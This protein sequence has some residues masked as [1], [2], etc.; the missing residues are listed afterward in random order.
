MYV[1]SVEIKFAD[2]TSLTSEEKEKFCP[3]WLEFTEAPDPDLAFLKVFKKVIL[4]KGENPVV[5]GHSIIDLDVIA[6]VY[7]E[8]KPLILYPP[9]K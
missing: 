7:E 2:T 1:V 5:Y 9:D 3:K 8:K 6:E 4:I